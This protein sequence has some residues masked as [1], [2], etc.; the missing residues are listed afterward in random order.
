MTTT[1]MSNVETVERYTDRR[2]R[3][4]IYLDSTKRRPVSITGWTG[5]IYITQAPIGT[6]NDTPL[7][8]KEGVCEELTRDFYVDITAT[9]FEALPAGSYKWTV[10]VVT[11]TGKRYAIIEGDSDFI[12]KERGAPGP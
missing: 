9:E 12:V 4:P 6:Y 11:D 2:I 3:V 10:R 5:R 1:L 7:V 8:N